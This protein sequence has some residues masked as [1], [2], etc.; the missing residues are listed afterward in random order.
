DHPARAAQVEP[1]QGAPVAGQVEEGVPGEHLLAVLDQP[2]VECALLLGGGVQLAPDVGAA[3]GGA[4]PG[5]PQPGAVLVG[6]P[7]ER[8]QL[9][10]V[11]PGHHHRQLGLGQAG[12]G[13]RAQ[14]AHRGGVGAGTAHRV[15]DLRGGAVQRY[16]HV[17]VAVGGQ[18]ARGG[19]GDPHAVG[20]ELDADPAA[21][22]VGD[23]LE[24]V[25]A[26]GRFAA[27]DVDV[28]D[29]HAAEL[30]DDGP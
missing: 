22:G 30:V 26:H 14:G 11:V 4:Q 19:R 6:D 27:A 10:G 25:G 15:V 23:Q 29:L 20:G 18:P 9:A 7:L 13:Q 21:G 24:E 2:V 17:H 28:E 5:Q 12:A 1:G 16:L 3:A 8:V